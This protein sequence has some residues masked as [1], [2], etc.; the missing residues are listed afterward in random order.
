MLTLLYYVLGISFQSFLVSALFLGAVSMLNFVDLQIDSSNA[1]ISST[2]KYNEGHYSLLW[3]VFFIGFSLCQVTQVTFGM[4]G[5]KLNGNT[6]TYAITLNY[7]KSVA[8]R[9]VVILATHQAVLQ[10]LARSGVDVVFYYID[11]GIMVVFLC[12]QIFLDR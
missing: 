2:I 1:N 6:L 8:K 11:Y 9:A 12:V 10:F 3:L 4:Q 7:A 5:M